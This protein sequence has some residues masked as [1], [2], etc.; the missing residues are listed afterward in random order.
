MEKYNKNIG[1][2]GEDEAVKYLVK[3]NYKIITRNF[4]CK[5]GEI[6]IIAK[7]KDVLAFIEV[8]ARTN[9]KYGNPSDAIGYYK[10]RKIINTA[11]YYLMKENIKNLFCRFDVVEVFVSN[12]DNKI[13][14]K[15]INLIKNA[16][17]A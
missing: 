6:D 3:H 4:S 9:D 8:K 12:D 16:F 13:I 1:N 11:K 15:D 17:M 14:D 2:F 7:D 5:L 10:K